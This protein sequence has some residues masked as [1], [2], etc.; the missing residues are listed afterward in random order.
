MQTESFKKFLSTLRGDVLGGIVS[1]IVA[2]P[3]ALAFGVATGM[4]ASA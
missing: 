1:A 3:Q 4:G 2:L